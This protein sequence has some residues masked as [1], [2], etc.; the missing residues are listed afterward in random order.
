MRFI[1]DMVDSFIDQYAGIKGLVKDS[2]D[3][4]DASDMKYLVKGGKN[5]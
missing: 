3:V 5:S 1:G 2:I 4:S